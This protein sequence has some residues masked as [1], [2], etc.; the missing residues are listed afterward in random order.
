M[1]EDMI[2]AVP[3]TPTDDQAAAVQPTDSTINPATPLVD[4]ETLDATQNLIIRLTQQLE[5]LQKKQHD[6]KDML[7][8]VF[9]NDEELQKAEQI[10]TE[11]SK[12]AKNRKTELSA[13]SQ[14]ID[15]KTKIAD[16]SEDIKM[17]IE[18]LNTHLLNYYQ[19][20]GSQT[21]DFPG[22]EE[23]E[24]VIRAKLKKGQP[25]Q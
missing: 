12:M 18:S 2:Q 21:V 22:G 15:L 9:D 4:A 8:G 3:A 17:V 23:R 7:K 20:T 5:D 24:M 1:T 16:L 11:Q 13:S 19:L 25:K 6:L 14:A 10:V